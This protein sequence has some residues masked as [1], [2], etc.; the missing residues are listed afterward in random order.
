MNLLHC[1]KTSFRLGLGG[2]YDILGVET[3]Y[4][5]GVISTN[6]ECSFGSH[7]GPSKETST[8]S[9][10]VTRAIDAAKEFQK[11]NDSE[12]VEIDRSNQNVQTDTSYLMPALL[13]L[14]DSS[15]KKVIDEPL[16]RSISNDFVLH[17]DNQ[18]KIVGVIKKTK[19]TTGGARYQLANRYVVEIDSSGQ[20]AGV[21]I[22][23]DPSD[24]K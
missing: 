1:D 22:Y 17:S 2:Y 16:A 15:G 10:P 13:S 20:A 19:S 7:A 5:D 3:S 14:V 18:T 8:G 12:E 6:I 9:D 23:Y 11:S 21:K 24:V 4:A